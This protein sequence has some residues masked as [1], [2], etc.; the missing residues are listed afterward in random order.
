MSFLIVYLFKDFIVVLLT[1]DKY[2]SV[3]WILPWMFLAYSL[4]VLS[5]ISTYELF[6][7]NQTKK[8]I[9]SSILPGIIAFLGGYFLIKDYGIEGALYN[10]MLT[11]ISYALFT[12]YA[13]S[14]YWRKSDNN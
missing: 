4:Y 8:L 9:L 5:M 1:D 13:V 10:Y 3:S 2:L 14:K 11:Y 12:F 6:A 7:H